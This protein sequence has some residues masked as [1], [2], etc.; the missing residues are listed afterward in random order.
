[1]GDAYEIRGLANRRGQAVMEMVEWQRE[2]LESECGEGRLQIEAMKESRGSDLGRLS[3][4][5]KK[6]VY[7]Y[8][9]IK[10]G[11]QAKGI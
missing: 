11:M 10:G 3:Y 2:S 5:V 7:E 4:A 1:M 8:S 9:Y 6:E